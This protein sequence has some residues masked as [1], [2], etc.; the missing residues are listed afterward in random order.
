MADLPGIYTESIVIEMDGPRAIIPLTLTAFGS[1]LSIQPSTLGINLASDPPSMAWGSICPGSIAKRMFR[2]IN[3]APYDV[4]VRWR[5]E[6]SQGGVAASQP[7]S[8]SPS[9]LVVPCAGATDVTLTFSTTEIG[10]FRWKAIGD[11]IPIGRPV[12]ESQLPSLIV[13]LSA[14]TSPPEFEL[15]PDTSKLVFTVAAIDPSALPQV[16]HIEAKNVL[17]FTLDFKIEVNPPLV[18]SV[19][20]TEGSVAPGKSNMLDVTLQPRA[21][22]LMAAPSTPSTSSSHPQGEESVP[23]TAGGNEDGG[24][25][26]QDTDNISMM[27]IKFLNGSVQK[28]AL[29][30]QVRHAKLVTVPQN[31][32]DFGSV[33]IGECR[34]LELTVFNSSALF[35]SHWMVSSGNSG[36]A[37]AFTWSPSSGFSASTAPD[38]PKPVPP[39][40]PGGAQLSNKIKVTFC[41]REQKAYD[42]TL[43]IIPEKAAP[44]MFPLYGFG[45]YNERLF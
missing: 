17:P 33:P 12:M 23:V 37:N 35:G 1:P 36:S 29:I 34:T 45:S 9:S 40:T 27:L 30:A 11:I 2:V 26:R 5:F 16:R 13:M 8:A 32:L 21:M 28:V 38:A 19:T 6:T 44:V 18:F 14:S 24:V 15:V 42:C 7:F 3:S 39:T 4:G 31:G 22:S 41:P 25:S 43:K 20:P 10:E